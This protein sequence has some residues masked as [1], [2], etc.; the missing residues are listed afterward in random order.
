MVEKSCSVSSLESREANW[1]QP[2]RDH[3]AIL[4]C[5]SQDHG[6]VLAWT[7]GRFAD[8][9]HLSLPSVFPRQSSDGFSC[10]GGYLS[11]RMRLHIDLFTTNPSFHSD[12]PELK[13]VQQDSIPN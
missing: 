6:A 5:V 13:Q 12:R 7:E 10:V 3:E 4:D 2:L 11:R 1:A 9:T 8:F